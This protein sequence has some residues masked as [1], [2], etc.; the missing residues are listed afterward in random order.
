[1]NS[2]LKAILETYKAVDYLLDGLLTLSLNTH[3]ELSSRLIVGKSFG[4]PLHVFI[5]KEFKAKEYSSFLELLKKDLTSES[6]ILVID[7]SNFYQDILKH[8]PSEIRSNLNLYK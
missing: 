1:M 4:S 7:E 8:T 6:S 5:M 3:S 2:D